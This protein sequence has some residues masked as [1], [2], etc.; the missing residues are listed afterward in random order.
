MRPKPAALAVLI[1]ISQG[2]NDTCMRGPR[3]GYPLSH[4]RVTLIDAECHEI[5]SSTV[6]FRIAAARALAKGVLQA[7]LLL[8]EQ[9]PE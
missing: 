1:G 8:V 4:I 6:S 3:W 5:D 2:L 7:G 9:P